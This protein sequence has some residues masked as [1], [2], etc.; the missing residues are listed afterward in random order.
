MIVPL[1]AAAVS[2]LG[3]I[4]CGCTYVRPTMMARRPAHGVLEI[5]RL[6]LES[7]LE[8]YHS[9]FGSH[10]RPG[11]CECARNLNSDR[12]SNFSTRFTILFFHPSFFVPLGT[13]SINYQIISLSNSVSKESRSN[14]EASGSWHGP[15]NQKGNP[16]E[17]A[18]VSESFH[19]SWNLPSLTS[20]L[21]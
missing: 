1:C 4:P 11:D 19:P 21:R 15:W 14:P 10:L 3:G 13:I 6:G 12:S 17:G 8:Q 2:H 9:E 7:S 5:G 16:L 18:E 20:P